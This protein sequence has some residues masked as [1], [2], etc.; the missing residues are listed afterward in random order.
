MVELAENDGV[1]VVAIDANDPIEV[2]GVN[3]PVQLAQLERAFQRREAIRLM[4]QG[5]R[6]ADPERFDVRGTLECAQDVEIDVNCVFEA[7]AW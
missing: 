6:I 5:V 4:E 3:S 2:E 7:S 1:P